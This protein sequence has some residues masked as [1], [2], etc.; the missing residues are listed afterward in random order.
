MHDYMIYKKYMKKSVLYCRTFHI[1]EFFC[2]SMKKSNL[3]HGRTQMA[4]NDY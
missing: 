2:D 3:E 1:R 4:F